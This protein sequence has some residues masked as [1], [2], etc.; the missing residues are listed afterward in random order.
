[1][2]AS[3]FEGLTQGFK[4]CDATPFPG[5]TMIGRSVYLEAVKFD[6]CLPTRASVVLRRLARKTKPALDGQSVS[7]GALSVGESL[8]LSQAGKLGKFPEVPR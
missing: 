6:F 2:Q 5:F 8:G 1:M 7:A 4:R 3:G